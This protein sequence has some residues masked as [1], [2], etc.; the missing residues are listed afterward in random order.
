M[1]KGYKQQQVRLNKKAAKIARQSAPQLDLKGDDF[2]HVIPDDLNIELI[3]HWR[4][5]SGMQFQPE[6]INPVH[7]FAKQDGKLKIINRNMMDTSYVFDLKEVMRVYIMPVE[8]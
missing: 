8:L 6:T 2:M 1:S 7:A 3:I 4:N 5:K